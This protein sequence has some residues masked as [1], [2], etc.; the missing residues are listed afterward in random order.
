MLPSVCRFRRSGC[1][2]F[3]SWHPTNK[4]YNIPIALELRGP[5]DINAMAQ[6][7]DAVRSQHETLRTT[8][9][10]DGPFPVQSVEP[11]VSR[12]AGDDRS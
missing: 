9:R 11:W 2:S 4:A 6:A 5:L 10:L 8:Y 1:G 3:T 7:I 12:A